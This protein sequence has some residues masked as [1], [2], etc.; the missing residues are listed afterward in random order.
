MD[1]TATEQIVIVL[2]GQQLRGNAHLIRLLAAGVTCVPATQGTQK[3]ATQM[4][5]IE[6][7]QHALNASS[8]DCDL[9]AGSRT[10]QQHNQAAPQAQIPSKHRSS[11]L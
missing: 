2:A 7:V 5:D 10:C 9:L 4:I 8:T 11:R 3:S 1:V 6:A